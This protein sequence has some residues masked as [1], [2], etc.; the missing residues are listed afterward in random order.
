MEAGPLSIAAARVLALFT[1]R[2]W[3][4]ATAES[5]TGGLIAAALTDHPGSSQVVECGL[6]VYSNRAKSSLL[7]VSE[8]LLRA[9]GAVSAE[10][11]VAMASGALSC[12]AVDAAI[13]VTG[14]AGPSGG[15]DLK[16]VGL[17]FFGLAL[18]ERPSWVESHTFPGDRASVRQLSAITALNLLA[19]A[20][21]N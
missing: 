20:C 15:S 2:G 10:V 4:L 3:R 17:V 18:R 16:P 5:C 7:G 19:V 8:G 12:A 11:A 9:H 6:V 21:E 14:I 13:A 1:A